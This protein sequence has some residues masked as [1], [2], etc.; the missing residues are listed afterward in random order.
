MIRTLSTLLIGMVF[1][2]VLYACGAGLNIKVYELDPAQGLVRKQANEV[3]PFAQAT[4]FYCV[5]PS[6]FQALITAYQTCQNAGK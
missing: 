5:S 3:I 1:G 6:D 2:A 4:G